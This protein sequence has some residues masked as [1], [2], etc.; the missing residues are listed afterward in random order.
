MPANYFC[1]YKVCFNL[2]NMF[3]M[4]NQKYTTSKEQTRKTYRSTCRSFSSTCIWL[5]I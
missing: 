1:Q 5:Y 2:T 3:Q 4:G